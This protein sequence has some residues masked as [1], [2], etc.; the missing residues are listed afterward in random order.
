MRKLMTAALL[1]GATVVSMTAAANERPSYTYLSGGY[2]NVNPDNL[3]R[4]D[5]FFVDGSLQVHPWFHLKADFVRGKDSPVTVWRARPLAGFHIPLNSQ[6]DFVMRAGW[7]FVDVDIDGVGSADAD[8]F[9][10]QAGFRTMVTDG[11]EFNAFI[12]Y[13]DI[14]NNAVF[15]VGAVVN[16]T[17]NFAGQVSYSHSSDVK[18]IE[19][20]LRYY[21][22]L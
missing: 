16:F 17:R 4:L 12:G 13:D 3:S 8:G 18:F 2:A 21:F 22:D 10:G 11:L 1:A 14:D 5:G 19:V 7:S 15:D 20:G 9:F 6:A